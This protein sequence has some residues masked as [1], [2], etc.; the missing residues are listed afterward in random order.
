[1]RS[2]S[3]AM[4]CLFCALS[5]SA[6]ACFT[7]QSA[8]TIFFKAV[9][10]QINDPVAAKILITRI[11]DQPTSR[12]RA[13]PD[14]QFDYLAEAKVLQV[15]KGEINETSIL[16]VAPGSD[17]DATLRIGS[18]GIVIG[19]FRTSP[20]GQRRLFVISHPIDERR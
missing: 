1:M 3:L 11:I 16:V 2:K 10:D 4:I 6:D 20:T 15:M 14:I 13:D 19:R 7:V 9:P 8:A 5:G 12:D 18:S 17:C